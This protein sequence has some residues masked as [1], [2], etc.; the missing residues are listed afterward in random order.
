VSEAVA[1]ARYRDFTC[2]SYRKPK[3]PVGTPWE[4]RT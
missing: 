3:E 1:S 2:P 4:D